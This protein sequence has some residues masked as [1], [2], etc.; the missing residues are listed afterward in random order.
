MNSGR[1]L[2]QL[3]RNCLEIRI[4]VPVTVS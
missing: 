1:I 3:D 4:P 2:L